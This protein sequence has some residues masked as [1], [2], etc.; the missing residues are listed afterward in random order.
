MLADVG[1]ER[2]GTLSKT[3]GEAACLLELVITDL[4]PSCVCLAPGDD[5]GD[6][7]RWRSD[8]GRR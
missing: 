3:E 8:I 6:L 1:Q 5:G 2:R 4:S 7:Q